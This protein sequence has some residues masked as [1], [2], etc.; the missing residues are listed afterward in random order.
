VTA[1]SLS[2]P[3]HLFARAEN[4]PRVPPVKGSE[5]G[6]RCSCKKQSETTAAFLL[7]LPVAFALGVLNARAQQQK[8]PARFAR[9]A[10]RSFAE[11]AFLEDSRYASQLKKWGARIIRLRTQL[12]I[13]SEPQSSRRASSGS[14]IG[15]PSRI[16]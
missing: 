13:L 14:M 15:M 7:Q 6:T 2:R 1:A 4:K 5:A 10:W 8:S 9:A 16:G 12:A 3:I 11:Y